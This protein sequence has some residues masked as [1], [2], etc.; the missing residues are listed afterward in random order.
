MKNI[1]L[2]LSCAFFS[3]SVLKA[4]DTSTSADQVRAQIKEN[5]KLMERAMAD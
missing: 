3:I 5:S 2:F 4:Q 1:L